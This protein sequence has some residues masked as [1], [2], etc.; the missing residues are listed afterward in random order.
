MGRQI[1]RKRKRVL[2]LEPDKL[3]YTMF[4]RN[5]VKYL[6]TSLPKISH[7]HQQHQ[8]Q[9]FQKLVKF[10]VDMAM[11]QSATEFSWGNALKK[12]LLQRE[13]DNG[14][15]GFGFSLP[16]KFSRENL[17]REDEE[18]EEHEEHEERE[19][20]KIENGLMKLRKIVPG[21]SNGE[22]EEDDLFKQTESYIKCLELQVNVLRCLV[23]TNTN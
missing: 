20:R 15:N 7:H 5:Y 4:A 16:V 6:M 19:E 3:A 2:S 9:N 23:D 11:A 8:Q 22:L 12:K 1:L 13:D 18:H 10:E 14:S 21:G 17:E